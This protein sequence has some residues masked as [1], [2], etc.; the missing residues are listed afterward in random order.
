VEKES[1][2]IY[3]QGVLSSY[4]AYAPHL[5]LCF[6]QTS[7]VTYEIHVKSAL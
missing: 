1:C 4:A 6:R 3:F 7:G 2:L 5:M